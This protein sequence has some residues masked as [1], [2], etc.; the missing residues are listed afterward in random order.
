MTK[1]QQQ[2]VNT[3]GKGPD[4]VVRKE[5]HMYPDSASSGYV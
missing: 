2:H 1:Q 5:V 3:T 4:W